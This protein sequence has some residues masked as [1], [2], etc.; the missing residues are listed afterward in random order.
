MVVFEHVEP[1]T[2]A[3]TQEY[4]IPVDDDNLQIE[5]ISNGVDV[6]AFEDQPPD[7][8]EAFAALEPD[9]RWFTYA[10]I[11]NRPQGLEFILEAAALSRPTLASP[12]GDVPSMIEHRCDGWLLES[13]PLDAERFASAMLEVVRAGR[14]NARELG[15]EARRRIAVRHPLSAYTSRFQELWLDPVEGVRAQEAGAT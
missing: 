13:R 14:E 9:A 8:P 3:R 1:G 10:G 6:S 5:V 15:R 2:G 7:L 11:L 12:V 4:L